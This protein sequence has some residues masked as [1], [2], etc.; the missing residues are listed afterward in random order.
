MLTNQEKNR[1]DRH[2]KL[3]EI[4]EEGQTKLKAAKVL[5]VGAGGLGSPVLQYLVAAGVGT[6]GIIDA[7]KVSESNLQRQI[8]FTTNDVGRY[9]VDVAIER[10]YNQNS[11]VKLEGYK[12]WLNIENA[13]TIF[14]SY[15]I[16]VDGTDNFSTRYLINDACIL[17][18]KPFVYASIFKFVN[19][20][21]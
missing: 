9:K 13:L 5:V 6:V 20:T 10:L 18:D 14:E 3:T 16:I 7:D 15:D 17:L 2:I 12:D 21:K 8:L 4:G 1:Y 11:Y 19:Y